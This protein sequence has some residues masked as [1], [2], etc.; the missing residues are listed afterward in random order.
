MRATKT[1][2]ALALLLAPLVVAGGE[3]TE[4]PTDDQGTTVQGQVGDVWGNRFTLEDGEETVLVDAGPSWYQRLAIEAGE[5]L[6]VTG[7]IQDETLAAVRIRREDGET[8]KVRPA[9]GDAPWVDQRRGDASGADGGEA[10]PGAGGEEAAREGGDTPPEPSG[11]APGIAVDAA[12]WAIE[13][14]VTYG[15]TLFEEIED[16]GGGVLEIEGWLEDDWAAEIEI[17]LD[18]GDI[19][20]EE[21]E[22]GSPDGAGMTPEQVRQALR[23]AVEHGLE[24]LDEIELDDQ[25]I[26]VEGYDGDGNE[27]EIELDAADMTIHSIERD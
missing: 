26:E 11:A 5:R 25:I 23:L 6:E 18:T 2:T 9:D 21:R 27:L 20:Q 19:I 8:V 17:A 7:R 10:A 4:R 24:G 12:E 13:R 3:A 14:A 16:E 15:F 1:N 22:R